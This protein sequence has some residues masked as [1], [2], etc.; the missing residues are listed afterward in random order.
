MVQSVCHCAFDTKL[1]LLVMINTH[2]DLDVP[3][4]DHLHNPDD[5]VKYQTQLLTVV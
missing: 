4:V 2:L 3:A 5:V 1:M